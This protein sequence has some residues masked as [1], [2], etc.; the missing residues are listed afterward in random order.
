MHQVYLS[1]TTSPVRETA[2][3]AETTNIENNSF[4]YFRSFQIFLET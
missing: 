4:V 3:P 1:V 2:V